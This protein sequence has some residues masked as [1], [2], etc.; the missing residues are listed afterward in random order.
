MSCRIKA[1][2][3]T[4]SEP[5]HTLHVQQLF[6]E[7]MPALRRFVLSLLPMRSECDDVVQEVFLL[8]TAKAN[9]FE[10]GTNF[11]AWIFAMARFKVLETI[12]RKKREPLAISES[13]MAKL[14]DEPDEHDPEYADLVAATLARCLEKLSPKRRQLIQLQYREDQTPRLIAEH[15]GWSVNSVHVALSRA[16]ADLR[17]CVRKVLPS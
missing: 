16:R 4:M 2:E 9:D 14:A 17:T 13:V 3:W 10:P 8:V 5:D 15:L 6:V 12:R 1:L 11:R 7:H